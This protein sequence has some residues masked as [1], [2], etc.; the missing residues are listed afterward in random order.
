MYD[1]IYIPLGSAGFGG[2]E[3]SLLDLAEGVSKHGHSILILAEKKLE[4]TLFSKLAFDLG[5]HI[6]WVTWAPE[7]NFLPNFVSA[8][9][10][11]SK[12]RG[13][14]IHFNI[15]WRRRMWIIPIIA[16]ILTRSHLIGTMRAMPDPH[17]LVP[18]RQYLGFI[19][20]LNLWHIPEMVVGWMWARLLD[21]TVT[22]NEKDFPSRLIASYGFSSDRIRVIPNGIHV[23]PNLP[24]EYDR[25]T[26]REI[27]GIRPGKILLC[28]AGRLSSEKGVTHLLQALA[29]L[30][31]TFQ[32]VLIGSGPQRSELESLAQELGLQPKVNFEG[33]QTNPEDILAAS[34]IVVVPSIWYEAFGRV[35]VEAFNQ[36]VPVVASRIGGMAELFSDGV[37]GKYT[38]PGDPVA[39]ARTLEQMGKDPDKLRSMGM[40][41]RQLVKT[42][43]SFNRVL[44]Q[45]LD[46]YGTLH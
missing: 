18:R 29:L 44:S 6:E 16:R 43:Y 23:R 27:L 38:P 3:R 36:G 21:I 19:P 26:Q 34:D 15:S 12:I 33:F 45:Y 42:S 20:G 46:L 37:E 40:A 1:F 30:P 32:L 2:A 4:N 17:N 13:K 28:F 41:G 31:E 22:I 35:V 8:I 5:L 25:Q 7:K 9:K 10:T 11:F 14:V 39:L 24:S